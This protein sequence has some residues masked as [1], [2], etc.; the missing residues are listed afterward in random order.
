MMREREDV[1]KELEMNKK[2][3]DSKNK[4]SYGSEKEEL[5]DIIDVDNNDN[6]DDDEDRSVRRREFSSMKDAKF[7]K[8]ETSDVETLHVPPPPEPLRLIDQGFLNEC[9]QREVNIA[10]V[11]NFCFGIK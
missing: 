10:T 9:Y 6:D 1:V 2:L 7:A 11:S 3:Q 4:G 5:E 8:Y